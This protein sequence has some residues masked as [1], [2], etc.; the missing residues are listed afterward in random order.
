MNPPVLIEISAGGSIK[1]R[2]CCGPQSSEINWGHVRGKSQLAYTRRKI[3]GFDLG[4]PCF[5]PIWTISTKLCTG[6]HRYTVHFF[7]WV[8]F[9]WLPNEIFY[10]TTR[11]A[12]NLNCLWN[13][14]ILKC[15]GM[16]EYFSQCKLCLL[17]LSSN[18]CQDHRFQ[19]TGQPCSQ[20]RER[21]RL[22]RGKRSLLHKLRSCRSCQ[23]LWLVF[24]C[25]SLVCLP[26][27]HP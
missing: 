27:C 19:D 14:F 17:G 23:I 26:S 22:G 24:L 11:E 2:T 3:P 9:F 7:A 5:K 13:Q 12:F 15:F 6:K 10:S 8:T 18:G 1:E 21:E 25:H 20:N 4:S 16:C